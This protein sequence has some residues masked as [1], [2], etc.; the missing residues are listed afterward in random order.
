MTS[1]EEDPRWQAARNE[2]IAADEDQ[3]ELP[4]RNLMRAILASIRKYEIEIE[5]ETARLL[6]QV[7][8][9]LQNATFAPSPGGEWADQGFRPVYLPI[10]LC[11]DIVRTTEKETLT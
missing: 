2:L 10:D 8:E 3:D 7:A 1:H 11:N 5:H 4:T 6:H 9:Y